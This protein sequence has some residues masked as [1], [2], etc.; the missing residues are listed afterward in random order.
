MGDAEPA[1]ASAGCRAQATCSHIEYIARPAAD[2]TQLRGPRRTR[3]TAWLRLR[4]IPLVVVAAI[5]A[6]GWTPSTATARAIPRQ[7]IYYGCYTN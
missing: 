4:P 1:A 2:R 3:L 5:V 7:G 6:A